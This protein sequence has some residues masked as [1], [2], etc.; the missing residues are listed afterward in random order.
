MRMLVVMLMR[1][2][3]GLGVTRE[4]DEFVIGGNGHHLIV[5]HHL[6]GLGGLVLTRV[7]VGIVW[8][9]WHILRPLGQ[10]CGLVLA[11]D[12]DVVAFCPG[13]LEVDIQVH[14][15]MTISIAIAIV[16]H[17]RRP[18]GRMGGGQGEA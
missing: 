12:Q 7:E 8:G 3:K 16:I 14:I 17:T 4:G 18:V 11:V 15:A 9:W 2:G 6:L 13:F 5:L 1:M 10:R